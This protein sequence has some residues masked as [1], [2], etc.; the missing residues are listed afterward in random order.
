MT[1]FHWGQLD[2]IPET[3]GVY[4]LSYRSLDAGSLFDADTLRWWV[5]AAPAMTVDGVR[6]EAASVQDRLAEYLTHDVVYIGSSNNLRR[7]LW[8]CYIHILGDDR[9][10]RGSQ[11][12]KTL[13]VFEQ[14]EISYEATPDY[15]ARKNEWLQEFMLQHPAIRNEPALPFAN[16]RF[17]DGTTKNHGISHVEI[18][19]DYL[20]IEKNPI[21]RDFKSSVLA[22]SSQ[23]G[24]GFYQA[25][26]NL[27]ESLNTWGGSPRANK[28]W[29]FLAER[30]S[31]WIR[32]SLRWSPKGGL[33]GYETTWRHVLEVLVQAG[34]SKKKPAAW[35]FLTQVMAKATLP[36]DGELVEH[37]TSIVL[38]SDRQE[39]IQPW[40]GTLLGKISAMQHPLAET[41]R[42]HESCGKPSVNEDHWPQRLLE[43][44]LQRLPLED[45]RRRTLCERFPPLLRWEGLASCWPLFTAAE[46]DDLESVLGPVQY[47]HD[48][49]GIVRVMD[50]RRSEGKSTAAL[51]QQLSA[52]A[53]ES[54]EQEK[55]LGTQGAWRNAF[56][57]LHAADVA[58]AV[59]LEARMVEIYLRR[60][61]AQELPDVMK[62]FLES[63]R[64]VDLIP[65]T[66]RNDLIRRKSA[67]WALNLLQDRLGKGELDADNTASILCQY[68][69]SEGALPD[70]I[71][72]LETLPDKESPVYFEACQKMVRLMTAA[73]PFRTRMKVLGLLPE[74]MDEERKKAAFQAAQGLDITVTEQD[75]VDLAPY[76]G[77]MD[78]QDIRSVIDK[79]VAFELDRTEG[80]GRLI[81][82]VLSDSGS[83]N[84]LRSYMTD[85]IPAQ[86]KTPL[87]NQLR[88]KIRRDRKIYDLETLE[89]AVRLA[90]LADTMDEI[91]PNYFPESWAVVSAEKLQEIP[92]DQRLRLAD[93][94]T[95]H[96]HQDWKNLRHRL[97]ELGETQAASSINIIANGA[98]SIEGG[99]TE[100]R[101]GIVRRSLAEDRLIG[102]LRQLDKSVW[103]LQLNP[104]YRASNLRFASV[105]EAEEKLAAI[106]SNF[107]GGLL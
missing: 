103:E 10:H 24:G 92:P 44:L 42:V 95:H 37:L 70:I 104:R 23:Y 96:K 97:I 68:V 31:A 51:S 22:K 69:L 33:G 102:M 71:R 60:R 52:L 41:D 98:I 75:F 79:L 18:T 45:P 40:I 17:P 80:T 16:L 100:Y 86:I 54:L 2:K 62:K 6:A 61:D 21:W 73:E 84:E 27:R 8:N 78:Q 50:H 67:D 30:D 32:R 5:E 91:T 88:R 85:L 56:D 93:L 65:T 35:E 76:V 9:P 101:V 39:W 59:A 38:K 82:Q 89:P 19:P 34:L 99:G 26:I 77:Q 46:K 14:L 36:A 4:W 7:R 57:V 64:N 13:A 49:P 20:A 25:K 58:D 63:P 55:A 48:L 28:L 107:G 43:M 72:L 87:L 47:P 3:A 1:S 53:M 15:S 105:A 106:W 12:L 74:A 94:L 81:D 66:F 83:N 29:A 90:V 11:W